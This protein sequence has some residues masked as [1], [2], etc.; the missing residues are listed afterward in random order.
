VKRRYFAKVLAFMIFP[1]GG[2][3]AMTLTADDAA[4]EHEIELISGQPNE[5]VT[6]VTL[7]YGNLKPIHIAVLTSGGRVQ[8]RRMRCRKTPS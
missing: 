1:T 5:R 2:C 6:N 7:L 4:V 3:A 8:L